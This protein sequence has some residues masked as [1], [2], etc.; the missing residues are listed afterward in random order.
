LAD[1]EGTLHKIPKDKIE[2]MKQQTKSIMPG[3]FRELLTM[4]EFHDLL[5]FLQTL[6]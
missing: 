6:Q 3:N 5:A 4:E 2:K 1:N